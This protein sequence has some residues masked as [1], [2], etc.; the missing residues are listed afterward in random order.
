MHLS[1]IYH[2]YVVCICTFC[3]CIFRLAKG[4]VP[5]VEFR[6]CAALQAVPSC[7]GGMDGSELV[8][9]VEEGGG[10]G[11]MREEEGAGGRRREE[12]GRQQPPLPPLMLCWFPHPRGSRLPPQPAA[13][14]PIDQKPIASHQLH[15]P[16]PLLHPSSTP[17]V[18]LRPHYSYYSTYYYYYS[19]AGC[20]C[21]AAVAL[22]LCGATAA[23]ATAVHTASSNSPSPPFPSPNPSFTPSL[24]PITLIKFYFHIGRCRWFIHN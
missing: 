19:S 5:S 14:G 13:L 10:G 21:C 9:R 16:A 17:Y 18:H 1:Q 4:F 6:R 12:E 11:R 7:E 2:M 3:L 20:C 24:L 23:A 15:S 22:L 8:R